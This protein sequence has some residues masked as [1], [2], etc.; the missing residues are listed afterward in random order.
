MPKPIKITADITDVEKKV[1]SLDKLKLG[2]QKLAGLRLKAELKESSAAFA[3]K[4]ILLKKSIRETEN[5][6]R[7][8]LLSF[9]ALL[10]AKAQVQA[11][12]RFLEK[13]ETAVEASKKILLLH[14][15]V[16][17]EAEVSAFASRQIRRKEKRDDADDAVSRR[18]EERKVKREEKIVDRG[19]AGGT[20]ASLE[21]VGFLK[22]YLGPLIIA[23]A[24]YKLLAA[25]NEAYLQTVPD[26]LRAHGLGISNA[27]L[28]RGTPEELARVGLS[29]PE[30]I[31]RRMAVTA[32]A[33]REAGSFRSIMQQAAFEKTK[34][35]RAGMMGD[36]TAKLRP[37][38]GTE[39]TN[40]AQM[41]LQAA[42]MASGVSEAIGP[43][44]ETMVSL[45]AD[46]N[47][48]GVTGTDAMTRLFPALVKASG[49]SSEQVASVFGGIHAGIKG[50][51]GERNALLQRAFA[52]QG[53]GGNKIGGVRFAMETG[54]LTGLNSE[55]YFK[56]R[57]IDPGGALASGLYGMNLFSDGGGLR[58][59]VAGIVKEIK[60]RAGTLGKDINELT[61]TQLIAQDRLA[62]KLEGIK[63]PVEGGQ[64]LRLA[65]IL[66]E[67][68][69]NA[70][71][72][73]ALKEIQKGK[74]SKELEAINESK[75]AIVQSVRDVRVTLLTQLGSLNANDFAAMGDWANRALAMSTLGLGNLK[76]GVTE[77]A[78]DFNRLEDK[79]LFLPTKAVQGILNI[80]DIFKESVNK[81]DE[82]V[83]TKRK[84]DGLK[85][86]LINI[87]NNN[88]VTPGN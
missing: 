30:L 66:K 80:M 76:S 88:N 2:E 68:K 84:N 4:L 31:R 13:K 3:E 33:G 79:G 48:N 42:I 16:K 52:R 23:T 72:L 67:T 63:G 9:K 45:L 62:G 65:E 35:L 73:A 10:S 74:P 34:G 47:S 18:K 21:A 24:A 75:A 40:T 61:P 7:R 78:K 36:L 15:T 49:L 29:R 43:M 6:N 54:G 27:S 57:G 81:F 50:A 87:D 85:F 86:P 28:N 70:K 38:F 60:T 12:H 19:G 22:K 8:E 32:E 37:T 1:K 20:L 26:R 46:I 53:I 71:F 83:K 64:F 69:D 59:R 11:H 41:K 17:G 77:A 25:G 82:S 51:T 5:A 39:G 55:E 44:L 14:A 56:S 58:K